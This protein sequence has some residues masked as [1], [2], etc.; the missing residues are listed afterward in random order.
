MR[1]WPTTGLFARVTTR[2]VEF[3]NGAVLPE[4]QQVLIY[5]VFNHRNKA[6]V[7][8]ADRF[9]PG[10]WVSGTA[11]DDWSFNFMSHGP[12]V[13]P[14]YGL[15]VFLG[16]AVMANLIKAGKLSVDGISMDPG[17][18]LPYSVDL[19]GFRVQVDPTT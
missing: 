5:N 9:S 2:E 3:P 12:Q 6:E 8:Y 7:P 11:A 1:L 14:G 17:K 10:E 18:P 19:F 13:C 16:Q 4:G 15:S